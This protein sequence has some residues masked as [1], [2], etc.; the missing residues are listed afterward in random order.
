MDEREAKK[1]QHLRGKGTY[2]KKKKEEYKLL[3]NAF[4]RSFVEAESFD[5][6]DK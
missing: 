1:M 6:P 3:Q 5:I 4:S 2:T